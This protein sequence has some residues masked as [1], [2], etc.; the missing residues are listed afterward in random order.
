MMGKEAVT[1]AETIIKTIMGR[2]QRDLEKAAVGIRG[3]HEQLGS[4]I[5]VCRAT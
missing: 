3:Y 1:E 4:H 2:Q 5:D